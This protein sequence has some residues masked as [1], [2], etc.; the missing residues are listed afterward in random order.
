MRMILLAN[1]NGDEQVFTVMV[2][3]DVSVNRVL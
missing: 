1:I 2:T 3:D